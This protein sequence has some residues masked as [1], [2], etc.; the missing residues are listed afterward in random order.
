MTQQYKIKMYMGSMYLSYII[1]K[2]K[3]FLHFLFKNNNKKILT[4]IKINNK[5]FLMI[6]DLQFWHWLVL[7][8]LIII[9]DI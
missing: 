5:L 9:I 2:K 7:I 1:N 4:N 6:R 3:L 8:I